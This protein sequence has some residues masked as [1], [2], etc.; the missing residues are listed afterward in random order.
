MIWLRSKP[1]NSSFIRKYVWRVLSLWIWYLAYLIW[2][3]RDH[4]ILNSRNWSGVSVKNWE[5][6]LVK[7]I[8]LPTMRTDVSRIQKGLHGE[9]YYKWTGQ[10]QQVFVSFQNVCLVPLI[11]G[12]FQ[13]VNGCLSSIQIRCFFTR[14]DICWETNCTG[15]SDSLFL[16]INRGRRISTLGW[17]RK[18]SH[19]C[20]TWS[21]HRQ[22]LLDFDA[23]V[24][25]S[26]HTRPLLS[27]ITSTVLCVPDLYVSTTVYGSLRE[28]IVP[29]DLCALRMGYPISI[30]IIRR[31]YLV[32]LHNNNESVSKMRCMHTMTFYHRI[33]YKIKYVWRPNSGMIQ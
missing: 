19:V 21:R 8:G 5:P 11:P 27:V 25:G 26:L 10:N 1:N 7:N 4:L 30:L 15:L 29:D 16:H 3:N 18:G 12:V 22:R 2:V 33:L 31:T 13:F 24:V 14:W 23:R 17:S 6:S 28:H 32:I 9:T 20:L